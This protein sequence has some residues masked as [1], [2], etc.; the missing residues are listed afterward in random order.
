[1]SARP[2]LL[3]L[4]LLVPAALAAAPAA[5]QVA[6]GQGAM[7]AGDEQLSCEQL[8]AEATALQAETDA[9][10]RDIERA[11]AQQTASVRGAQA[12]GTAAGLAGMVP[13]YGGMAGQV[14]GLA[15]RG[16]VNGQQQQSVNRFESLGNRGLA[17]AERRG[18]VES[19][20]SARCGTGQ[21]QPQPPAEPLP[22]PAGPAPI[23]AM[24][25]EA[26]G[27][28]LSR[29]VR[30]TMGGSFEQV[31]L[32]RVGE[33]TV[34]DEI[35]SQIIGL[36]SGFLPGPAGAVLGTVAGMAADTRRDQLAREGQAAQRRI[37]EIDAEQEG[38]SERI[39]LLHEEHQRRCA[40]PTAP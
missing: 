9:M 15:A 16:L 25:C 36:A 7:R 6:E 35:A 38:A 33:P 28:E 17:I 10:I 39:G 40:R 19:L 27:A 26:L 30:S 31:R 8:A 14:A 4:L 12:L 20:R 37:D 5:A 1:M 3:L 34:G 23:A 2:L 11:N 29:L 13:G 18:Q 21:G 22:A 32:A 24:S